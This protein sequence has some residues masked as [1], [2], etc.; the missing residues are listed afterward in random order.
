MQGRSPV[1]IV[2]VFALSVAVLSGS[3]SAMADNVRVLATGVFATSLH[4]LKASFKSDSGEEVQ[5]TIANAGKVA[6]RLLAGEPA[7]VVMT[8]SSGVDALVRQGKLDG[9]SKILIGRMRLGFGVR[10]G[11]PT[12]ALESAAQVRALLLA[13]PAVAFIDPRGGATAGAFIEAALE[14]LG[15]ADTIRAKAILCA[16][17]SEVVA[18]LASGKA[19][20][21]MT[22]ASEIIGAPGVDF[23][24]YLPDQLNAVSVYA[25]ATVGPTPPKSATALL[26]FMQSPAAIERLHRAGWDVIKP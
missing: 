9:S 10:A 17:G 8:S 16:D 24:G 3:T 5:V 26:H 13:A 12:Q 6:E 2:N 22:Q 1:K 4:D 7:D 21:G 15:I 14:K 11:T 20:I 25:A 19:A 23:S 18:A